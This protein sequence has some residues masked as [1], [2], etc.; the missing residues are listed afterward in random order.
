MPIPNNVETNAFGD[1][2]H[3]CVYCDKLWHIALLPQH[4]R[5]CAERKIATNLTAKQKKM[6]IFLYIF[7]IVG[8]KKDLIPDNRSNDLMSYIDLTSQDVEYINYW[9]NKGID[10]KEYAMGYFG[11]DCYYAYDFIKVCQ[12]PPSIPTLEDVLLMDPFMRDYI[13][14]NFLQMIYEEPGIIKE[15]YKSTI[16]ILDSNTFMEKHEIKFEKDENGMPVPN[17]L[18]GYDSITDGIYFD[19]NYIL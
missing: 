14:N 7:K 10:L 18:R 12:M 4:Y 1:D 6:E 5:Q 2:I 16:L 17:A 13:Q 8:L 3:R 9:F 11:I 19:S 15:F